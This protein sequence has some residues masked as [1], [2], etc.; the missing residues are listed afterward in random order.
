MLFVYTWS[1]YEYQPFRLPSAQIP[2]MLQIDTDTQLSF[3]FPAP[4]H[5]WAILLEWGSGCFDMLLPGI[6][7]QEGN[8]KWPGVLVVDL[9]SKGITKKWK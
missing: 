7:T 5:K 1:V 8:E 4:E 3:C 2:I 6:P 9:D